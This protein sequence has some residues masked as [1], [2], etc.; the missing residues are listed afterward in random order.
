M[1]VK[2]IGNWQC[3]SQE[4]RYE[5]PWIEV[6][7]QTVITPGGGTGIYGVV[8]FKNRAVGVIPI[9]DAG[10]T[11]LVRQTRY[12]LEQATWEIPEGG[13]PLDEDMLEAAKRELEEEVGLCASKW[14]ELLEI[15]TSNSVT[16]EYGKVFVATD[17]STGR[18]Q[19]EESEDIEVYKLPL[20][21][22]IEMVM[23]GRITDSLSIAGL[24]KLAVL[25]Q[26]SS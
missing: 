4:T 12:P 14:Q 9:D 20:Q 18:Q 2:C 22:A 6:S 21:Q 10:N 15:H 16:D 19:L 3:L 26:H 24:L 11:W 8:H 7:H 5:N 17:L 23:D 13:A 1:T 25:Q